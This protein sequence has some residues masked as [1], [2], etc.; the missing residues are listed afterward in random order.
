MSLAADPADDPADAATARVSKT[1]KAHRRAQAAFTRAVFDEIAVRARRMWPEAAT[2]TIDV[3]W[4]ATVADVSAADGTT[5]DWK[6]S[7]NG[8]SLPEEAAKLRNAVSWVTSTDGPDGD[9]DGLVEHD[10]W[11]GES[12]CRR[13]VFTLPT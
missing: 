6:A 12:D 13:Y 11:H 8:R 7:L 9:V 4:E 1:F 10:H 5:I 3:T 2:V